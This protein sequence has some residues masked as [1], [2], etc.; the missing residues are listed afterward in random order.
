MTEK[1][2][3]TE[4]FKAE[5]AK[6]YGK[7]EDAGFEDVEIIEESGQPSPHYLR[8][9]LSSTVTVDNNPELDDAVRF[10]GGVNR[11]HVTPKMQKFYSAGRYAL[12]IMLGSYHSWSVKMA[13]AMYADGY[14]QQD[15]ADD[16]GLTRKAVRGLLKPIHRMMAGEEEP[17][18]S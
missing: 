18:P 10:P 7:L 13:S 2:Y 16:M 17:D 8:G 9:A 14:S 1:Y 4:A 5:Q 11:F 12:D 6:W 15:I 3:E